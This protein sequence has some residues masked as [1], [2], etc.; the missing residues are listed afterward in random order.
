[1]FFVM[2]I[3]IEQGGSS[4]VDLRN[5]TCLVSI[6]EVAGGADQSQNVAPSIGSGSYAS[7]ELQKTRFFVV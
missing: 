6:L 1:M 5:Y 3:Y 7:L 2:P 4:A